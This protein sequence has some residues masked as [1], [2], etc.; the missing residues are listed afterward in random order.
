MRLV[1]PAAL[2]G[3]VVVGSLVWNTELVKSLPTV[4]AAIIPALTLGHFWVD[5]FLWRMRDKD[6]AAWV[7][8]RFGFVLK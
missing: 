8:S 3:T 5:L 6:R 7:K 1:G 4:G 2:L